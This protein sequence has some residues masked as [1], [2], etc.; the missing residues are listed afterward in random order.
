MDRRDCDRMFVAVVDGGSFAS[1]AD[2]LGTSSGQASKLI[3]RLEAELGVQLLTRTTR[4]LSL[5]EAGRAYLVGIRPLLDDFDA[6]DAAVR[7]ASGAPSGRLRISA[8]VSFGTTRLA[9]VLLDFAR[10]YADIELDVHFSDRLVNLI[11]EGYDAAI[12]IGRPYDSSLVARKLCDSRVIV[13]AASDYLL[14]RGVPISPL[15]LAAHDC[16]I[17]TNFREALRWRFRPSGGEDLIVPVS[18]R[19]QFSNAEACLSAAL[20]GL[21]IA[22]LPSFI[23]GPP[24]KEGKLQPLFSSMEEDRFG[25]FVLYPPA[26]HLALKVRVLVDFLADAFKGKPTWDP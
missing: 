19:L 16:I 9:P 21:G 12:R 14:R 4:A 7:N 20:A 1:A 15:D 17:D 5:T 6:L 26:R 2:R 22:R 18:G 3:S 10:A 23:A 13:A 24:L 8:P 25:I 11:D